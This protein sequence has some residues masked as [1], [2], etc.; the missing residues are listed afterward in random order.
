MLIHAGYAAGSIGGCAARTT[1]SIVQ[2]DVNGSV[3]TALGVRSNTV[4]VVDQNGVM[5]Y[6]NSSMRFP[7]DNETLEQVVEPLLL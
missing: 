6:E 5:V 2:D 3:W 4:I 7:E 1:L